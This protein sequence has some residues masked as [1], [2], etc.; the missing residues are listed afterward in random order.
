MFTD[1]HIEG[2]VI[3]P[4][5]LYEDHRGWLSEVF[6]KDEI[7][8]DIMPAMS[9]VSLTRPRASRGPHEHTHQTDHFA[10]PGPGNFLFMAWDNRKESPTYGNRSKAVVGSNNK[11][12]IIVPPGVVHGYANISSEASMAYNCPNKL[13]GGK[14]KKE[15]IDEIRHEDDGSS[16]FVIDFLGHIEKEGLH[17]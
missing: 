14:G 10:F 11:C 9:Y 4:M 13:F 3:K 5:R 15:E 2:L 7:P 12:V 6:R 8:A 17:E 1:G 16:P